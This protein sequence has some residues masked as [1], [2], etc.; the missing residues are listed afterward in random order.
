MN[1]YDYKLQLVNSIVFDLDS[2]ICFPIFGADET[3]VRYGG[4]VPNIPVIEA[5][6]ELRRRGFHIVISTARR[7]QTHGGDLGKVLAD[8]LEIT[9]IWLRDHD[10]PYDEL[11]F[12]KPHSTSY[13]VDDKAM[14]PEELIAWVRDYK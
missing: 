7:M 11:N 5:M 3:A 6:R 2:T 10:V 13:Y 1:D 14:R 4:A 12:G 9:Q 8:V